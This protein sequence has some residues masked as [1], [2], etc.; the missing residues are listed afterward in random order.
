MARIGT[1]RLCRRFTLLLVVYG[2]AVSLAFVAILSVG[3]LSY[4][5][6]VLL[7]S[8]IAGLAM[9]I[10]AAFA[11]CINLKCPSCGLPYSAKGSI[12]KRL[13]LGRFYL[14]ARACC[15]C[16]F[17]AFQMQSQDSTNEIGF[18]QPAIRPGSDFEASDKPQPEVDE[19][20]R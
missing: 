19:R 1:I 20:S 8:S 17:D 15:N 14:R 12:G 7:G 18:E 9:I 5:A 13:L 16:G 2:V 3:R 10:I 11:V 6:F 4:S